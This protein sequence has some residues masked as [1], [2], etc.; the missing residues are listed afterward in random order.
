MKKEHDGCD[1]CVYSDKEIDEEPCTHCKL[2]YSESNYCPDLWQS[3]LDNVNHPAHYCQEGSIECIDEM[4]EV[5]GIE[6]VKNFCICN[7]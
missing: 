5:F 2:N 7:V 3:K 4:V 6:S 1:G